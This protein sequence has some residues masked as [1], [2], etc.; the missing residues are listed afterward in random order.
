MEIQWNI[1]E[2][3]IIKRFTGYL[4]SRVGWQLP[5]KSFGRRL[6]CSKQKQVVRQA[7]QVFCRLFFFWRV[8][9]QGYQ[10]AT[11]HFWG[12]GGGTFQRLAARKETLETWIFVGHQKSHVWCGFL[13]WIWVYLV[14]Y[15]YGYS[16]REEKNGSGRT[17]RGR[18]RR[19]QAAAALKTSI[20]SSQWSYLYSYVVVGQA[21][22][23]GQRTTC[24]LRSL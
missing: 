23:S 11:R 15:S 22:N 5:G 14:M 8:F 1:N 24:A 12:E 2:R 20:W 13:A 17:M 6:F 3:K 9:L 10:K 4:R 18:H 21:W 16:C 7:S 19:K